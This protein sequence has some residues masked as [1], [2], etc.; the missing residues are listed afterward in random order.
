M[1]K[2]TKTLN[3][4]PAEYIQKKFREQGHT[5]VQDWINTSSVGI[6]LQACTQVLNYGKNSGVLVLVKMGAALGF[7]PEELR[8]I[9]ETKGDYELANL[10]AP[11]LISSE[12]SVLLDNYRRMGTHQKSILMNMAKEM[13]K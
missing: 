13:R 1:E 7:T 6:S 8:W 5:V 4:T 12:E 10:I 9:C 11:Q 2:T 3:M